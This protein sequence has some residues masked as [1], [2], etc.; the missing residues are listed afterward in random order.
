MFS[1]IYNRE[2][3]KGKENATRNSEWHLPGSHTLATAKPSSPTVHH[4]SD[5]MRAGQLPSS[6][7]WA[8]GQGPPG[9]EVMVMVCGLRFT[10]MLSEHLNQTHRD[11]NSRGPDRWSDLRTEPA[12]WPPATGPR[13]WTLGIQRVIPQNTG[14]RK[15]KEHPP[16]MEESRGQQR[17]QTQQPMMQGR[18]F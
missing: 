1:F 17:P 11:P 8:L 12:R 13:A 7:A 3:V 15:G 6:A 2:Y 16:A 18:S 5:E 4:G 10:L 14:S 9:P